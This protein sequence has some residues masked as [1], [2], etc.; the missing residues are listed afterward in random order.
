M[1]DLP[2]TDCWFPFW[3]Y[4]KENYFEQI[5]V[6]GEIKFCLLVQCLVLACSLEVQFLKSLSNATSLS[7]VQSSPG[8][9]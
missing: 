3:F 6:V 5:K 1:Q 2:L 4:S 9:C 7:I 8:N